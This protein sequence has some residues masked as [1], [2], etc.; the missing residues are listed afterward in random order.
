[1]DNQI[2]IARHPYGLAGGIILSG[3]MSASGE[4]FAFQ[5]TADTDGQVYFNNL[6]QIN[7]TGAAVT[8]TAATNGSTAFVSG[9]FTASGGTIY[10][11]ICFISQSA[12][13]SIAYSGSAT[14][15]PVNNRFL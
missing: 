5:A 11:S 10:G 6:S 9:G 1:M 8:P 12:G 15:G 14:P 13:I 3:S 2:D 4:F 7:N